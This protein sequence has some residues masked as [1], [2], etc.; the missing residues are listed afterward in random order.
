MLSGKTS[1]MVDPQL[2][3]HL[4]PLRRLD[5]A[6]L[7][8]LAQQ[9]FVDEVKAGQTLFRFGHND[10]WSFYLIEGEI[11]LL[12][13]TGHTELVKGGSAQAAGPIS[14]EKPR[15]VVA[16]TRTPA[17]LLRINE[18]ALNFQLNAVAAPDATANS[19][20]VSDGD[21]E[22]V[23]F[24]KLHQA[25]EADTLAIPSMPDIALRVRDAV[26]DDGKTAEDVARII[27]V[28]PP[29]A[30]RMIQTANSPLYRG[31][32]PTTTLR[33]AIMR[34]GLAQTRNLVISITMK[35]LFTSSSSVLTSRMHA[36][37]HHTTEVAALSALLA[38]LT[39]GLDTDRALLAGLVHDI[40]V[41]PI[42]GYA[43][44]DPDLAADG[45][46]LDRAIRSLRGQVGAMILRKW[47]FEPELV[48]VALDAEDW[49]RDSGKRV[50]YCDIV[51]IAQL[52]SFIGDPAMAALPGLDEVPA[53]TKVGDGS[54]SP[55]A[56]MT[57]IKEAR[58]EIEEIQKLLG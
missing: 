6:G 5:G 38:R 23:L 19:I 42:L 24:L 57:I 44:D 56:S 46:T 55:A 37:W 3:S 2:L 41:L 10:P 40:G 27:Q 14:P 18:D 50:D 9:S 13:R 8:E 25:Y 21:S 29:L 4:D 22:S 39:P 33:A 1:L 43:A 48:T 53:F 47:E 30:A 49:K 11:E 12:S 20:D 35:Q 17:R 51:I 34:L 28:D 7:R 26:Q 58:A 36:V 54:L 45:N 15:S 31:T 16:R 52:H 32:S